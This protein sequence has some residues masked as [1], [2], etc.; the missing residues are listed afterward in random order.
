MLEPATV[1]R[2]ISRAADALAYAH[3]QGII[4]RDIKPANIMYDADK[5]D[6]KITDFGIARMTDTK[7]TKTGIILG[8]P[9]YMAPEQL[10]GKNVTGRSD[11]FSLGVTLYQLLTSHLP[12]EADSMTALMYKIANEDPPS[13]R[14]H[15]ADLPECVE[16]IITRALLKDPDVRYQDGAEMAID[17]KNC[18]ESLA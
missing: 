7:A 17:L 13:L 6:L 11:L 5:D 14:S 9:S 2:L 10:E 3:R 12:F 15:R 1:L 16:A 8:T 4:H 18:G